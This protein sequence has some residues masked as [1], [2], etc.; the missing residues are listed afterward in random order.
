LDG[1][2]TWIEK[3]LS[4]ALDDPLPYFDPN[5]TC[6][7]PPKDYSGMAADPRP[8][9]ANFYVLGMGIPRTRPPGSNQ[10]IF[11]YEIGLRPAGDYEGDFDVDEFDAPFSYCFGSPYPD[12]WCAALDFDD[13]G[14][15]DWWDFREFPLHLTGDLPECRGPCQPDPGHPAGLDGAGE[16]PGWTAEDVAKM[17]AGCELA[18]GT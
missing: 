16:P 11:F 9:T 2:S 7:Q 4:G 13:D 6:N 1:G 3:R 18:P 12:C 14:D 8:G 15:V 10:D 17:P 5:L